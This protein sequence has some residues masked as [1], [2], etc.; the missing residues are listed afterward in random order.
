MPF[1]TLTLLL[2]WL[3][4]ISVTVYITQLHCRCTYA[5]AVVLHE[6]ID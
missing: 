2:K 1:V 3:H 4:T 5:A 6:C